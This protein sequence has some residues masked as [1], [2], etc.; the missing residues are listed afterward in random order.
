MSSRLFTP[1]EANSALSDV[2]PVAER[3][4]Q[5]RARLRELEATQRGLVHTIGGNGGGH[6]AGDLN[7]AREEFTELAAELDE[8]LRRLAGFGV[9]VK[10]AG[11]RPPRLPVAARR[12]TKC[13]SAGGSARMTCGTGTT[14]PAASRA[15]NRSTGANSQLM[16]DFWQRLIVAAVVVCASTIAAKLVD[17]RIARRGL[18][19]EAI[20]RYRVLRRSVVGAIVFIGVLSA[21]LEIPQVRAIAGG[22]LAS[23]AAIGLVV[24]FASQRTIGNVLPES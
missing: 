21:L 3:L 2:R 14:S 20:T 8:C 10:D 15:G 16:S 11:R 22:I 5:V 13:C 12:S 24:G 17:R 18:P 23:S 7:T 1:A 6:A 9:L 19:P 4:V